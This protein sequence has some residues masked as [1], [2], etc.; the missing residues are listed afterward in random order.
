MVN[1]DQTWVGWSSEY[2]NIAFLKFAKDWDIPK[3]VYGASIGADEWNFKNET[4]EIAKELL[5]NFTGISTREVSTVK[6]IKQYLGFNATYVLDPTM[7]IDK[8]YYLNIIDN[9]KNKN[10]IQIKNNCILIYKVA[11]RFNNMESFIRKAKSE[12]G[13]QFIEIL[14]YDKEYIEKFLY[15]INNCKAVITNSYHVTMFS[16]IFNKP[17]IT[18]Y[19]NHLGSGRFFTIRDIYG[20]KDRFFDEDE[21]EIPDLKLLDTPLIMNSTN[22]DYYRNISLNYL[23]KNLNII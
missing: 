20:I 10:S 6:Y 15:V 8:K 9:Y 11:Q 19:S 13:Y 22:I 17:F 5:K 14:L 2:Y 12:S 18:F 3:F 4:N 21:N 23:K 16:I 1:S 7:L